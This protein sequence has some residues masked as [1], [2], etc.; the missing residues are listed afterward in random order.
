MSFDGWTA[1]FVI[2]SLVPAVVLH[3]V[4]HA[5][6]A[7][8]LGD[9]TA[10]QAGRLTLNPI[11]HVDPFGT[12]ILPGLL[13]VLALLGT[14]SGVVF[15]YAKPVPV[16]SAK[17]RRPRLHM[18]LVSLAGPITN[19]VLAATA[20]LVLRGTTLLSFRTAQFLVVW[21]VVNTVLTVFNLLPMPP[22]DGSE[23]VAAALPDLLRG[24]WRGGGGRY[25]ALALLLVVSVSP[26]MLLHELAQGWLA[27]RRGDPT[28]CRMGRMTSQLRAHIDVFG[29]II[30]P[31]LLL[32]PVLFG[33]PGLAFGYAKPMPIEPSNL[34][35]PDRDMMWIALAGIAP[36]VVLPA[37]ILGIV[38]SVFEG[39]L[40]VLVG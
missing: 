37:P 5:A 3:E 31:A 29:S 2:L 10:R 9:P 12:V 23:L 38:Y 21:I 39:L 30:V 17:L 18:L 19:A 22:L 35:D 6:T 16:N 1:A 20:V 11:R 34:R 36:N 7:A 27:V 25:G 24:A 15:G 32:L 28:P 33:R 26:A 40:D 8:A 14:G 4:S 13:I